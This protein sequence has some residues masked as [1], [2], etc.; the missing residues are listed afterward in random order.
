MGCLLSSADAVVS[1]GDVQRFPVNKTR[2]GL[3]PCI[4]ANLLHGRA[5][6]IHL[7]GTL[8]VGLLLQV[9]QPNDFV[10]VQRQQ[11]RLTIP[12]SVGTECIDLWCATNPTASWRSWHGHAPLFLFPVYTDYNTPDRKKQYSFQK[13]LQF[14]STCDRTSQSM[15]NLLGFIMSLVY[16][17]AVHGRLSTYERLVNSQNFFSPYLTA[18][19][20]THR[21]TVRWVIFNCSAACLA[22]IPL[23]PPAALPCRNTC[24][25]IV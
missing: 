4:F 17:Q 6:N 15:M 10:L 19:S 16:M 24:I 2:C 20:F 11:D 25:A 23:Q 18:F 8:L 5:G 21:R 1:P 14:P 7:R 3:A 12:T 13:L 9:N 22:E